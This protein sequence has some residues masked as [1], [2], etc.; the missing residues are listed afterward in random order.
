MSESRPSTSF[1]Q[2][3]PA[4]GDHPV[5]V[6]DSR[7]DLLATGPE[8]PSVAAVALPER[9]GR[10][11]VV[12][13][14]GR[15]AFGVVYRAYDDDLQRDVAIKVPHPHRVTSA[16]DVAF[17]LAEAR[18]L[19]GLDHPNI[20]PVYDLGRTEDGLCFVVS[21]LVEGSDLAQRLRQG[22]PPPTE[23]VEIAARVAEAL[24]HAHEH[25]LVHRDVK[26]G[27]VLLDLQGHPYVTDFGL[28][29]REEDFGRGPAFA[30]TPAYMSP[31]Q[32]RHEGHRVDARTDVYSLGAVFYEL[33]TGRRPFQG[34]SMEDVLAQVLTREPHPPCQLDGTMPRELDRICLKCL[35]KRA[36]DRYSSAAHLAEDLRHFQKGVA[37]GEWRV[38]SKD[39]GGADPATPHA[40]RVA[41]PARVVPKGLRTFDAGDQDFF[42]E[43]LPG[44]CDRDGLPASVR[45]WKTRLE[46]ADPDRT[47]S[48][49]LLYGPSGCGKSSLVKAGLLPRLAPHVVPVYVEA[50]PEETEVRLSKAL[51][52]HCPHLPA[53]RGLPQTLEALRR[54]QGLAAGR[55]LALVLD[56]FEQW[57]HV[58]RPE[59]DPEL[60]RALRQC[61]GQRVQCLLLVRD[62]FWLAMSR[63]LRELEVPLVEGQN[64]ALV[65]LFD[66]LHAR[67][68]L[69][70]FGRAYGRLPA[71]L[72]ALPAEQERFLDQAVAGLAQ[73]GKVISVRLSL[74]AEMV[75]G[76]PWSPATLSQVGGVE[77]LGIT[78][79]EE[80]FS[81]SS[82][83]PAHRLHQKA[84]RAVLQALL[85]EPG[86]TI[87]GQMRGHHELLQASGYARQP[88]EFAA[89][90]R[91]L[92][93]ELRLVT[94]TDPTSGDP[95]SGSCEPPEGS[96][97]QGVDTPR[98]PE[99][100]YQLTH[101]Y[102]VPS[103]REWLTRKQQ[104]TRRGRAELRLAERA[105]LW[106]AKPERRHLP[107]WWE[108]A[109][110][111]LLTR[112]KDWTAS[113]KQMMRKAGRYH[114]VRGVALAAALVTAMLVGLQVHDRIAERNNANEAA[115]LVQA[116]LGAD[117]AR[118][119]GF[120]AEIEAYRPWADPLLR[121]ENAKAAK[122]SRQKLHTSLALLPGDANQKDYLF[123][124]LLDAQPAE[125]GVIR[126]A[127]EPYK[128][129]LLE[130]L[131]TVAAK[132]AKGA[133]DQRLR[134]AAAL[135]TYDPDSPAWDQVRE[136]VANDLINVPAVYLATWMQS[137]RPVGRNLLAPLAVVFR[138]GKRRETE[139][140]LAT[141]VLADYAANHLPALM[142]LLL[143]A[144][145]KQFSVIYPKVE[146]QGRE[147]LPL[148]TGEIHRRLP[149]DARD[150]AKEKLAK[151]QANAAVALLRMDQPAR[152]W[153]LLKHS[154]DPTVRSHLIHRYG[155][156]RA[157]AGVLVK[158]LDDEPNVTIRRALIL[159][160]GPEEFAEESWTPE[161]KELLLKKL[162]ELYRTASDPGLHAAAE[163]L[164]RQWNEQAWLKQ[165]NDD[166]AKDQDKQEQRLEQIKASLTRGEPQWYVNGQGQTMVVIPGPVEFMMGSP[167][168]EKGRYPAE[169]Q[170]RQRIG[171]T[172]AVAAAPVTVEQYRKFDA[173]Y[174]VGVI[175]RWA[176]TAD[177]PV[178]GTDWFRA[179][180]Y[181]NWLSKQEGLPES[182]WCYE[183]VHDPRTM[184]ALAG[185]SVAMLGGPLGPLAAAG[186]V[187]PGRTDPKFEVGM[188]LA[189]DYL[190][191]QGYRLPTE[192]ET[193]YA[194]RA[195]A[196][197]SRY[198]GVSEDL[199][200]KYAWYQK[201]A[202]ERAWPV[203]GKKP[204]DIGLFETL[205]NAWTWCQER[206]GGHLRIKGDELSEDKEDVM[207]VRATEDRLLRGGAFNGQPDDL[208]CANGTRHEP[209]RRAGNIGFRVARTFGR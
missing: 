137:F 175:E 112:E 22:R 178:I 139:R 107:A 130:R 88:G 184:P 120:I 143:D 54:G 85:P 167:A 194:T 146:H 148:L 136:P 69:A 156:L 4:A 162:R 125:V 46:E 96:P 2:S 37:S 98:S 207:P 84:A 199:L 170:H 171:R 36:A 8:S 92:D 81:A 29:L 168:T 144:D 142:D 66:P 87:K 19:A 155:P 20:V 83:P 50:T 117:I 164:L 197:T 71:N 187:F 128:D 89:V 127:L 189:P 123:Q 153:P 105:A 30:G 56:Q 14:L 174:G 97:T 202:Q 131:W 76:K 59:G 57:L 74:F 154:P 201:N 39:V 129:Y 196:I 73:E 11:R 95:A 90:L 158:R 190:Q 173:R 64:T 44:P 185:S 12:G 28:A 141:D 40:P 63:F 209:A 53:D 65:D 135:A 35:A 138:D 15:G 77:G 58:R 118:V 169:P 145:E 200:E 43:L 113:Q 147:A 176:P 52:K 163:W 181:C 10:Y 9:L 48:V 115:R 195:G 5:P 179:A 72:A 198:F 180:A 26:P 33:L 206:D 172:F 111:R 70:E 133:E 3:D 100:Y 122:N 93:T 24:H 205:G 124:R 101:D 103:L 7:P 161:A 80:T 49:G 82:A 91:I 79:L 99:R 152:V 31:E 25:G 191:R 1:P 78:F 140:S 38:A 183:P 159:S 16:E 126:D 116:L 132:P 6:A 60:V 114:A 47:C 119:P 21:K 204:N 149:P 104:E 13:V 18:T 67:K 108:W 182:Q 208:R 55:K 165:V 45:F 157:D 134:A 186:G 61:D 150:D 203:G 51:R 94:P 86:T 160:L 166:W 17:Y 68:V 41:L 23:A 34:E 192:A 102:L 109:N 62:D 32:A 121:D 188:K 27:N 151:R 110:I 177:C 106:A 42:L 75:K 193:E